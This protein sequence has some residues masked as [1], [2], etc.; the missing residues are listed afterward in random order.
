MNLFATFAIGYLLGSIPFGFLIARFAGV[1]D[2]RRTGSGNIG[3]T[4]ITRTVGILPGIATLLLDGGKG[5]L[6]VWIAGHW[7]HGIAPP[8]IFAGL[9]AILGHMY[10]VWLRFRG[11]RGVATAIG[12]FLM[13]GPWAVLADLALWLAVMLIWRYASLSSILWAAA[14][15]LAMYWLYV[16]GEHPSPDITVGTVLAAIFII[17]RHRENLRRL[18]EGTEPRFTWHH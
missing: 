13:I 5:A 11:G 18:V 12:V 9:A 2:I 10:P 6:A 4:N 8:V 14:L 15:P 17:W 16:P 7:G 3:A 1:R